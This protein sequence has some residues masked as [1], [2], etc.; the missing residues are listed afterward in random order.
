MS[1]W[2]K[3]G[4]IALWTLGGVAL[5]AVAGGVGGYAWLRTSV[6]DYAG[7]LELAG[8]QAPIR[9]VRDAN[10]IPHIFAQS[11][12]DAFFALGFVH[13]QDR[14]WQLE[15]AR[16]AARAEISEAVGDSALATDRL[17]AA[18]DI[19][20][21]AART[22]ARN[23][24]A[25][26][27]AIRAYVA[28]VNAAIDSHRGAPAP[29]FVLLGIRPG[30]WTV[31][32]VNA[33]G[34]LIALG[35]GDW[36]DELM[37]ARLLPRLGC[38]KLRDLY[39]SPADSGPPTYPDQPAAAPLA[40][41]CGL[42]AFGAGAK[43]AETGLPHGRAMPAS[44]SW[45]VAG[46]RTASGKPILANDP[47]GGLTAPADYYPVRLNWPGMEIVGVTRAGSPVIASGRN[48]DIAWG[49]TDIMADQADLF[50]ERL[51]PADPSRYLTPDG[52]QPF[53]V[54]HVKIARKG[55]GAETL[56]LRYTRH[57]V[58]ISDFD[59]DAAELLRTGI[60]PGHVIALAGLEYPDGNPLVQAFLGMAEAKDWAGFH[61]ASRE[62]LLQH[63]FAFASRSG[64]IGMVS[65]G[66]LPQRRSDG[67][68]PVPGWDGR[69]DW[70][71][72]L[73]SANWPQVLNP[74][75]GYQ[76]NANNRLLPG[77]GAALDS[78]SFEPGWRA[79]RIGET[80]QGTQGATLRSMAALQLDVR[81]AEVPVLMPLIRAA[82]PHSAEGKA[83]REA[84]LAWDGTM[85]RDRAEPL[86]WAAWQRDLALRL[87]KPAMGP[88]ADAWLAQNKPRFERLLRPGS[89]W[90][91]DCAGEAGAALDS[92]MAGLHATQGDRKGWRWGELHA[93]TFRHEIFSF[94]PLIGRWISPRAI[95]GGD[96]NTVNA[97]QGKPWGDNPF[98]TDY[99]PRYRQLIDLSK[100]E[101]SLFMIAPGMSGN[102]LSP[103]FGHLAGR[104][105]EGQYVRITGS[106]AQVANGG[107]GTI[108]IEPKR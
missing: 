97:A 103:W 107:T 66:W 14:P 88:L 91:T 4:R 78:H 61:A 25:T 98:A 53:R 3:A 8:A 28:G 102:L 18:L 62:F 106:A 15:M 44:N 67:F 75:R 96:A 32:D 24:P 43:A 60:G 39:A 65:V 31:S 9:I 89:P 56:T 7:T 1:R 69:L 11:R 6:P 95:V 79:T 34:G 16:R 38:E 5:L 74:A 33:L 90:C 105:S 59:A 13:G 55:G 10:A 46:N 52:P 81:S 68:L 50:V 84:L 42:L 51:D 17:V 49:V 64:D 41:S 2:R 87:M 85:A 26:R 40:D 76:F 86:I 101:D 23:S 82:R 93:V 58:V 70:A 83:A 54:R 45:A 29:E 57:G 104:W 21:L 73:P 12:A 63:N 36:R 47:H 92:A 22:D 80:L 30:H 48:R 72:H 77:S 71:G 20:A 94:V 35:F 19:P 99:G 108:L 100:P 37:R 27:E